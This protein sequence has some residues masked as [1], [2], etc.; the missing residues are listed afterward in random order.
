MRAS[1]ILK[2][3]LADIGVQRTVDQYAARF[4]TQK[5]QANSAENASLSAEYY[6][7]VTDFYLHGWGRL[8]HFGVRKKGESHKESLM[9]Y[10]TYLADKLELK[11]GETCL[12]VG[13][14]VAGPMINMAKHTR[15]HI[16]GINN[17]PYQLSKARQFVME[18][19]VQNECSFLEC[20]WME[21]PLPDRKFDKAYAIEA[22]C[23]AAERRAELFT[24]IH[25]L[26]KP[27][28]LFGGYEWVMTD[29]FN[30]W[31]KEHS[32]IKHKI[33]IGD[34]ISNLNFKEDVVRALTEAG[35]EIIECR[36]RA[37]E[38]DEE[39]PWYL[40]LKGNLF[41]IT[42]LR[43]GP[44]G[45]ILMHYGLKVLEALRIVPKGSTKVH[46]ILETAADGLVRGG[47]EKIFTPM[48]FFLARKVEPAKETIF[49]KI[50]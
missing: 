16:T 2:T 4:E 47:E 39:T 25:R 48:L 42:H 22:T 29:K 35:F 11:K 7:L 9:R 38:C 17:L 33:E 50:S 41:S 12:D 31:N 18:E 1:Q 26:L 43:T 10:E 13:C 30:P 49:M 14:G 45:R 44:V 37:A 23:H 15:A 20:D 40:P 36:D 3:P 6:S 24:E 19:G 21:M 8:F 27:G 5:P 28:G 46:G 34:G 32:E